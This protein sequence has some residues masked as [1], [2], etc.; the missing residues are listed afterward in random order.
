VI[1]GQLSKGL[2]ATDAACLGAFVH[3]LAADLAVDLAVSAQ[4]MVAGDLLDHLPL[5]LEALLDDDD[6]DD[7]DHSHDEEG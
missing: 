5:A 2:T 6:A 4:G 7:H 3:G 1:G